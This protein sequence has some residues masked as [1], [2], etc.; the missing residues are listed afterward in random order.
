MDIT[1][2][3]VT[4]F[5]DKTMK[6]LGVLL[7]LV[8]AHLAVGQTPADTPTSVAPTTTPTSTPTQTPQTTPP[9]PTP[10]T[11]KSTTP[12]PTTTPT[13][14]TPTPT[15]TQTTTLTPTTTP[16]TT[17]TPTSAPTTT[18][19]T[20]T[21]TPT[22][23][24]TASTTAK[25]TTTKTTAPTSTNATES[26]TSVPSVSDTPVPTTT[27]SSDS[28][29]SGS[30][31]LTTY[32]GIGGGVVVVI[33]LVGC[34]VVLL[35]RRQAADDAVSH[36]QTSPRD[37]YSDHSRN[38]TGASR[39]YS[40]THST[41]H[42]MDLANSRSGP[43]AHRRTGDGTMNS[44]VPS[45][46]GNEINQLAGYDI[47]FDKTMTNFRIAHDEIQVGEL[48]ASGGFGVIYRGIFAGEQVAIKKCLPDKVNNHSAMESFMLEIKLMSKLDHPNIVRFVGV[49]WTTLVQLKMLT[50]YMPRGNVRML[51]QNVN[52]NTITL[53]WFGSDFNRIRIAANVAEALVY[54]HSNDPPI[55]HRDLKST[56]LTDFG[57]S[58]EMSEENTMTA[59]I[60]TLAWI[61]PEIMLGG[62]Y[63][64]RADIYSF[65][66][67]L[68]ELDLADLPYSNV[69]DAKGAAISHTRLGVLVAQGKVA[70]QFSRDCP[71]WVV[72]MGQEC[73]RFDP[74]QRP[75][76]MQLAYRL[77]RL[78]ADIK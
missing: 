17:E 68:N 59:E 73:L 29:S 4:S 76:A 42:S 19:T 6:K 1:P 52:A 46:D 43:G 11:T 26:P 45:F 47:R 7:L 56:K 35:R 74:S 13:P 22:P 70:P 23:G 67:L 49:A 10:T 38:T 53:P 21:P 3:I 54:L 33:L 27:K 65:G 61:A 36:A 78:M 8:A 60:G 55:I 40:Q 9:T 69:G 34:L 77:R 71:P 50:E 75:T 24:T 25:P 32:I 31:H 48:I 39:K 5:P 58:R 57:T 14:S 51:L 41:R 63:T 20:S 16:T 30:G 37:Y 72:Q 64:E 28:S 2:I 62:H 15:T 12:T 44:S 18:Q 66:V